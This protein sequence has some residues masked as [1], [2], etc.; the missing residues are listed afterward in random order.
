MS[1]LAEAQCRSLDFD[2]RCVAHRCA[3]RPGMSVTK[4]ACSNRGAVS[5][6]SRNLF[7][8][9]GLQ[10]ATFTISSCAGPAL[11]AG[12]A[13]Q[14]ASRCVGHNRAL[15]KGHWKQ[16]APLSRPILL[17]E[18]PGRI[19]MQVP[20]LLPPLRRTQMFQAAR[21][22]LDGQHLPEDITMRSARGQARNFR[23][24]ASSAQRSKSTPAQD[25]HCLLAVQSKLAS[26]CV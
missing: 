25:L 16:H 11:P 18:L 8:H 21:K 15:Q 9:C 17:H 14:M 19:P 13:K 10:C 5:A 4:H 20:W 12:C 23:V 24:A 7:A 2:R 1:C 3:T 26:K 6:W 22:Q